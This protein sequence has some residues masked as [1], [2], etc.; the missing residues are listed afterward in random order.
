MVDAILGRSAAPPVIILHS[1][2]GPH[3]PGRDR[4]RARLAN[5]SAFH[6]PRAE[7]EDLVPHDLHSVNL[8]VRLLN[9]YFDAGL[10]LQ[11]RKHYVSPFKRPYAF[12][13]VETPR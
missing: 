2:H 10:E 11:P 12:R 5:L 1:D 6:L 13:E 3:V 7:A 4:Q 8:F 9:H